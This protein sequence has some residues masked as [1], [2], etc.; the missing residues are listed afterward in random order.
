VARPRLV[1]AQANS[2][3]LLILLSLEGD[4]LDVV[5]ELIPAEDGLA[6]VGVF[7]V[8][9]FTELGNS[10][11]SAL[12]S[13]VEPTDLGDRDDP[14]RLRR[15]NGSSVWSIFPKR[16]MTPRTLTVVEVG[17]DLPAWLG[18]S[19]TLKCSTRL[20]SCAR[21]RNTY[22]IRKLTVGTMKKSTDT[23]CMTWFSRNTRHVVTRLLSLDYCVLEYDQAKAAATNQAGS[24]LRFMDNGSTFQRVKLYRYR[25]GEAK[26]EI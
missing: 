6:P 5:D 26:N 10:G 17:R 19:I 23:G 1:S 22:R 8:E 4:W 25:R 18:C 11:G 15:F 3:V 21:T 2:L 9:R 7:E 20:R 16:K 13:M 12:V 24:G 14:T